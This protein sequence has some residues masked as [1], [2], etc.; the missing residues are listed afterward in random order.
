MRYPK[1]EHWPSIFVA[2]A[3]AAAAVTAFHVARIVAVTFLDTTVMHEAF[4]AA[5]LFSMRAWR[6]GGLAAMYPADWAESG[7]P[8]ILTPYPPIF[9]GLWR[10]AASLSGGDGTYAPGRVIA[11]LGLLGCCVLIYHT[12][13][14]SG[15][16]RLAAVVFALAFLMP[17][18]V[19][20][21]AGVA[22]VDVPALMF[23][24]LGVWIYVRR[25]EDGKYGVLYSSLPF[26]LAGLTKQSMIAAPVAVVVAELLHRRWDRALMFAAV[27][28]GGVVMAF[29]LL[30]TIT[31]GGFFNATFRS[32]A[33]EIFLTAGLAL[34]ADFVVSGPLPVV[35]TLFA[36]VLMFRRLPHR[37]VLPIYAGTS[38]AVLAMTIGKPGANINY[39]IEPFA[40]LCLAG[41]AGFA[42]VQQIGKRPNLAAAFVLGVGVTWAAVSL[43]PEY[44]ASYRFKRRFIAEAARGIELPPEARDGLVLGPPFTFLL[45]DEPRPQFY[46]NDD[47]TFSV[48]AAWGKLFPAE[49]IPA[50][51][52]SHRISAVIATAE[53]LTTS[54]PR[55]IGD[56]RGGWHIWSAPGFREALLESYHLTDQVLPLR[57]RLFLPNRLDD[58]IVGRV[59]DP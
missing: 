7:H 45:I 58:P 56:W 36:V 55:F 32:L 38:L 44:R 12:A 33:D 49:R 2:L 10:V 25:G 4:E 24:L 40:A 51:L 53:V 1:P 22:R 48:M 21:W 13:R 18:P 29:F 23:A 59:R 20:V 54:R 11:I 50:D 37:P 34:A 39:Y 46:L 43:T 31:A 19:A 9:H 42:R 47:Y 16:G 27:T 57:L 5:A 17:I 41:A 26:I 14:R 28:G 30:N 15:A 35:L 3:A 6:D 52:R 8:L